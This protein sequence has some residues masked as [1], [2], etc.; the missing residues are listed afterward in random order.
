MPSK[1]S[2]ARCGRRIEEGLENRVNGKIY[3]PECAEKIISAMDVPSIQEELFA[4]CDV[5]GAIEESAHK[6]WCSK[7]N[8]T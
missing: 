5:C 3:G 8:A 1:S 6:F 7:A 4:F 2:C